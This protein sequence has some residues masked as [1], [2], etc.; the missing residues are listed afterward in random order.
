MTRKTA[1]RL[2]ILLI[3]LLLTFAV[4]APTYRWVT[5]RYGIVPPWGS[6]MTTTSSVLIHDGKTFKN[7]RVHGVER[8]GQMKLG[9]ERFS[10]FGFR[11]V[12]WMRQ[13]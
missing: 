10:L 9:L 5:Q 12:E 13:Q 11:V 3:L 8:P 2:A 6:R 7:A 1:L 4:A